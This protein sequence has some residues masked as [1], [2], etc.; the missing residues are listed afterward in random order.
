MKKQTAMSRLL[1]LLGKEKKRSEPFSWWAKK[2]YPNSTSA[3][4]ATQR[5]LF[6]RARDLCVEES[7]GLV[8]VAFVGKPPFSK[9][10]KVRTK[11]RSPA[12]EQ[13][14]IRTVLEVE[15]FLNCS[16][17][18]RVTTDGGEPCSACGGR[19]LPVHRLDSAWFTKA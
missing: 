19:A 1:R 10:D 5:F 13:N 9:G 15:C 2:L 3:R 14:V 4:A 8:T 17:F 7:R 16:S 12:Q 11:F 6:K 18:W